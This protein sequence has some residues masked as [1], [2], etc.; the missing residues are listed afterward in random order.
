MF[1]PKTAPLYQNLATSFVAVDALVHDLVEG[2]FVGVIEIGFRDADCRL[3]IGRE[4]LLTAVETH[5]ENS[6][7]PVS[8]ERVTS[9]AKSE[10]APLSVFRV[11]DELAQAIAKR[12]VADKLYSGLSTEFADLEKMVSKL[13]RERERE[14]FIE[15]SAESGLKG[16][17]HLKG[18]SMHAAT[19]DPQTSEGEESATRLID[20]C[21]SGGGTFDVYYSGAGDITP[22]QRPAAAGNIASAPA[23]ESRGPIPESRAPA[24][25]VPKER[26]AIQAVGQ[27][28]GE[29]AISVGGQPAESSTHAAEF[30][31]AAEAFPNLVIGRTA[32]SQVVEPQVATVT[33]QPVSGQPRVPL[34]KPA[35]SPFATGELAEAERMI[36]VKGLMAEIA[37]V[38]ES[39]TRQVENRNTFSMYLRAGQLKIADRYPF[40]DP[41]GS[42][43]EYHA[44]EIAFVGKDKPEVFIEGVTEALRLAVVGVVEASTAPDRLRVQIMEDL[45]A[46]AERSGP[47]LTEFGMENCIDQIIG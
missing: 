12:V 4:G 46:L 17:I 11:S 24:L 18:G 10:R 16:M 22:A 23:P 40:L 35:V 31:P 30:D 37:S 25:E 27:N 5:G 9:R 8:P 20:T 2:G 19:S 44:G 21:K 29:P 32:T 6:V 47:E 15:I 39:S 34:K 36:G 45:Y 14:W 28:N 1:I 42:E 13:R 38:I 7:L 26:A 41:F 33:D 3:V 43:F